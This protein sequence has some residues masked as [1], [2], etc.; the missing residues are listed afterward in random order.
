MRVKH[1][2]IAS[3]FNDDFKLKFEDQFFPYSNTEFSIHF[4]RPSNARIELMCP[5]L[6]G[7][8]KQASCKVFL[9]N[10]NF[11]LVI[12]IELLQVKRQFP[13]VL[14]ELKYKKMAL[15][16]EDIMWALIMLG[17]KYGE[18]LA[19]NINHQ[20][21][22]NLTGLQGQLGVKSLFLDYEDKQALC[23]ESLSKFKIEEE[24]RF[25]VG[26][27][28]EVIQSDYKCESPKRITMQCM[29]EFDVLINQIVDF[30]NGLCKYENIQVFELCDSI[31]IQPNPAIY[32]ELIHKISTFAN[33]TQLTLPLP[34][35][36]GVAEDIIEMLS[37]L[38][39]LTT[40]KLYAALFTK[41]Y[42][43]KEVVYKVSG[44]AIDH[45]QKLRLIQFSLEQDIDVMGIPC[46]HR[47][48]PLEI[49]VDIKFEYRISVDPRFGLRKQVIKSNQ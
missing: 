33:L 38:K 28:F 41:N 49:V 22:L 43:D 44:Y 20:Q 5:Q 2:Q 40:V 27:K 7:I 34:S 37:S 42:T 1:L 24:F 36:E 30:M 13:H 48:L 12:L 45:M 6:K 26:S 21:T 14:L 17:Q 19:I 29:C 32:K 39:K 16:N 15:L 10:E 9:H 25:I 4:F 8:L 18:Q 46:N 31:I 11:H 3:F 23:I 35:Y 47:A